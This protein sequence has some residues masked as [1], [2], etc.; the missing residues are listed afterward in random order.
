MTKRN[1]VN[2]QYVQKGVF[3]MQVNYS[4]VYN[5]PRTFKSQKEKENLKKVGN[6]P[7]EGKFR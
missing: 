6:T 4:D 7:K 5:K 3:V 1:S 2:Q